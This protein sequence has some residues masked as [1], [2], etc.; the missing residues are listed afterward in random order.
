MSQGVIEGV[1]IRYPHLVEPWTSNPSQYEAD[2]N[3]QLILPADWA[4]WQGLQDLVNQAISEKFGANTP[5]NLKLPWLN[6]FLQPNQQPDGPYQGCYY[7]NASGKGTKPFVVGPDNVELNDLQVKTL[8]FSG[9]KVNALLGFYG[10]PGGPGVGTALN[11]IQLLDNTLERIPDAGRNVTDAFK[12]IP[13]APPIVQPAFQGPQ[14]A[15]QALV[16]PT[17]G[18]N[19]FG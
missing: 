8:I 5:A 13:G 14:G 15:P 11:G 1:I 2:Y 7:I 17:G 18:G 10:Y 3:C 16:P 19:P 6:K 9:C 12:A 4:G